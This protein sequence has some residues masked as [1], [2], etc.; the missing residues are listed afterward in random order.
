MKNDGYLFLSQ[1]MLNISYKLVN[2]YQIASALYLSKEYHVSE[3][4]VNQ[5]VKHIKKLPISSVRVS[6]E[7]WWQPAR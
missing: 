1:Y 5:R 7:T 2:N 3:L 4:G 6:I